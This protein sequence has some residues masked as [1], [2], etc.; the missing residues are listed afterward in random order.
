[1]APQLPKRSRPH[2]ARGPARARPPRARLSPRLRHAAG[3]PPSPA[4]A[5]PLLR[6]TRHGIAALS[7]V[8]GIVAMSFGT[9]TSLIGGGA[10]IGA[11]LA[12]WLIAWLYR[13]GVEGDRARDREERARRVF[14]R[15]GRWPDS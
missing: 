5:S 12:I 10:L 14:D 6:F 11:G 7:V 8:A 15:T 1:M 3:D 4:R 9:A 13:V 2:V